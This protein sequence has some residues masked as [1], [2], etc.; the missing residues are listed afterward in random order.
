MSR[1]TIRIGG[2]ASGP[3]VAG[4]DNRVEVRRVA[5]EPAPEPAAEPVPADNGPTQINTA[6]DN[7]TLFTVMNGELHV[8]QHGPDAS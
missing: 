4:D 7:G 1:N 2:D 5:P 3:V 8:H 6:E